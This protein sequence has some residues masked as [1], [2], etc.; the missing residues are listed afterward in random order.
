MNRHE[1]AVEDCRK[2]IELVPTDPF[3][4]LNYAYDLSR[5]GDYEAAQ[6]ELGEAERLGNRSA[7]FYN[8]LAWL[9]STADDEKIRNGIKAEEAIQEARELMPNEPTIWDTQAAVCAELGRFEEAVKWQ[10]QY[11]AQKNLTAERRKNGEDRL[12]LYQQ[13]KAYRQRPGSD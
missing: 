13:R 4:R 7:W 10:K 1:E 12:S 11:L 9:L 2:T 8:N 5:I 3:F 6:R